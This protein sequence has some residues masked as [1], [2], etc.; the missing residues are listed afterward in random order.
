MKDFVQLL[1]KHQHSCHKF[2][3]QILKNGPEISEW[4]KEYA[5]ASAAQFRVT[6]E[7]E[8]N[9]GGAGKLTSSLNKAFSALSEEHQ[10]QV[11]AECDAYVK[12]RTELSDSSQSIMKFDKAPPEKELTIKKLKR[13]FTSRDSKPSTRNNSR[14]PSPARL[15]AGPGVFLRRWQA[16]V[17]ETVITAANIGGPVRYGNDPDVVSAGPAGSGRTS[18]NGAVKVA[19][20]TAVKDA[21]EK[22]PPCTRTVELLAGKFREILREP[23]IEA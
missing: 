22:T 17:N 9:F 11:Q 21:E 7:Q 20:T 1:R 10:A 4:Y 23:R 12:Y 6:E 5:K 15:E 19:H 14:D 16:Y 18:T 2:L 8:K 13:T 3:H